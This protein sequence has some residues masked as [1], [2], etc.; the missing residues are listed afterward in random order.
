MPTQQFTQSQYTGMSELAHTSHSTI[1]ASNGQCLLHFYRPQTKLRK[2]NAFTPVCQSFYSQGSVC[3][4][5]CWDTHPPPPG[6]TPP[7]QIPPAQTLPIPVH[8]G[9]DMATAADGTHPTGMHSCHCE[10]FSISPKAWHFCLIH[11]IEMCRLRQYRI[12]TLSFDQNQL[13]QFSSHPC[14]M[15]QDLEC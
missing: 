3:L 7:G 2:G 10:E 14:S 13:T 11:T 6:Q 9:I 1:I 5:A 4:S 8:T 12:P 15:V